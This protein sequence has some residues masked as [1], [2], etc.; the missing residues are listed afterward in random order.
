MI[1]DLVR[2]DLGATAQL[3]SVAVEKL[4]D[5]ETY[6]T[7][8][9]MVSTVSA[10]LDSANSPVACVKAAFPPGSMAGAPKLRTMSI[11]DELEGGPR[12]VYSG[13]I[14][15]FSLNGAV[16]LNVV[17]RTLVV[18]DGTARY[19]VGGAIVALSDPE[20]EYA[21]TVTKAAPLLRLFDTAEF[22]D[23]R[24]QTSTDVPPATDME[25]LRG[26][27]TEGVVK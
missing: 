16:D 7:V 15:Y 24:E 14:G 10:R 18:A 20:D 17:I 4:F 26:P 2:H 19:G 3:G 5:I 23:E 6:S 25:I 9:Q 27:D 13:A 21:E 8:H 12:G 1:V 22:P 11:I